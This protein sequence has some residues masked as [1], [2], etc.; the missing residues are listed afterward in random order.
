MKFKPDETHRTIAAYVLIFILFTLTFLFALYYSSDILKGIKALM[1]VLTPLFY[2]FII[3]FM[4]YPPANFLE[5]RV[6]SFLERKQRHAMWKRVLS[7]IVTYLLVVALIVLFAASIIPQVGRSYT[8]LQK[9][10]DGYI[11]TANQWIENALDSLSLLDYI[12]RRPGVT[13]QQI[14]A[15]P[16]NDTG[17]VPN[18]LYLRISE[19]ESNAALTAMRQELSSAVRVNIVGLLQKALNQIYNVISDLSPYIFD[20]LRTTVTEAKNLLLGLILSVYFLLMREAIGKQFDIILAALFQASLCEKIKRQAARVS[21]VFFKYVNSKLV[22]ALI[23]GLLC[24]VFMSLLRLPYAP[25]ISLLVGVTNVIPYVGP[26][27]GAVP[28]AFII[29]IASPQKALWFILLI[30]ALQQADSYLIEPNILRTQI[31]LDTV[32]IIISI[33][34][35]GSLYGI[36]GMFIGVPVFTVLYMLCRDAVEERLRKKG[37]PVKTVDYMGS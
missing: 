36:A 34:V 23:I 4:L 32:W 21:N 27:L 5:T 6:F 26:F 35:M 10:M 17:S 11:E 9:K 29:F 28:G 19:A 12:F 3:A 16:L 24:F 1:K 30:I 31:H 37:L 15:L 2:G 14:P 18:I 22:D 33:V 25:L 20:F 8:D 7:L 13:S